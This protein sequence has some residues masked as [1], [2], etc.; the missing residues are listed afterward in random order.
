MEFGFSSDQEMLRQ[1]FAKFLAKECSFSKLR[2][3]I[4]DENGFSTGLWKQLCELGWLGL[5]YD[6]KYGGSGLS[7][8]DLF[9]VFEEIGAAILPSP[10]F[11]SAVL[12]GMLIREAGDEGLKH[13]YLPS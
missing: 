9:I 1:S 6:E 3:W 10:F 11:T 2:E 12:S 8:L 7:F 5:V 13:E 4:K